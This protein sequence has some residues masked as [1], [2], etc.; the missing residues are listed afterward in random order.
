MFIMVLNDGETWTELSG[1]AILEVRGTDTPDLD[2]HIKEAFNE[3]HSSGPQMLYDVRKIT[4]FH[5]L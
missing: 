1:C 2:K 3:G 4:E 5:R